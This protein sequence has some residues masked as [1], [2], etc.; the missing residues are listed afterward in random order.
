MTY[1]VSLKLDCRV[2]VLVDAA[3]FEEAREKAPSADFAWE[4]V[5]VID[6]EPVNATD[7]SGNM[8]DY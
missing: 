5:E 1:T 8:R 6:I 2:N 7:P 3:S 4:D